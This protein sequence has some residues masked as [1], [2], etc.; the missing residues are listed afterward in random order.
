[1][2][3]Y[4][5]DTNIFSYLGNDESPHHTSTMRH[6][7]NVPN[8]SEI[9]I[10]ILTLY[11]FQYG[12]ALAPPKEAENLIKSKDSFRQ[13]FQPLDLTE[14]GSEC[15]GNLKSAYKTHTGINQKAI[16]RH[17]IDFMLASIAVS[18]NAIFVSNDDIFQT[19]KKLNSDFQLENWT[20]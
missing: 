13:L 16:E 9:Y 18:E 11:E 5:L 2:K 4:L 12:I 19:I 8:G 14:S 10:S 1:M 17:T 20:K 3:K 15:F 6:L 7:S